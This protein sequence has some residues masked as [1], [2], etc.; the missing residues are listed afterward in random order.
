[1]SIPSFTKA[2]FAEVQFLKLAAS[3]RF[4]V[5]MRVPGDMIIECEG[6][7]AQFS[8][9]L[10]SWMTVIRILCQYY[11]KLYTQFLS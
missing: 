8:T 7:I 11:D 6:D 10:M 5:N 4:E 3:P 1:M 2:W 9:G